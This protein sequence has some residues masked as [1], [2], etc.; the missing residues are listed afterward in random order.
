MAAAHPLV[1]GGANEGDAARSQHAEHLAHRQLVRAF[2][3]QLHQ[4]VEARHKVEGRVGER[5]HGDGS[6]HHALKAPP[7]TE[8][9]RVGREV[10]ARHDPAARVTFEPCE[11]DPGST[12]R[13]KDI[14]HMPRRTHGVEQR[15]RHLTHSNEPPVALFEREQ[16]GEILS[17]QT[18]PPR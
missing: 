5:Q 15:G 12:S 13:V 10:N 17:P 14:S 9:E 4:H 18:E 3:R 2:A 6:L 16:V 8:A 11:H 1:R 7:T